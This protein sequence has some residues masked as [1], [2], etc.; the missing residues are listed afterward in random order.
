MTSEVSGCVQWPVLGAGVAAS[1]VALSLI[2]YEELVQRV[3]S[4]DGNARGF[5]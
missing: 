4:W 5:P 3:G 1:V 2:A